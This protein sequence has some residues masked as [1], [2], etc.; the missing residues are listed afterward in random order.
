MENQQH[1]HKKKKKSK[2]KSKQRVFTKKFVDESVNKLKRLVVNFNERGDERFYA[3]K[4]DN[5]FCVSKTSNS[6]Y[7][8]DYKEF[9][10]GTT[11][12]I[13]VVMYFGNSNNCNR[14]I[15]YLKENALGST[16]DVD[17]DKK[18]SDAL[19]KKDQDYLIQSLQEQVEQQEEYIQQ[20]EEE[21]EKSS[22]KTDI[23]GILKEGVALLGAIKGLP[24]SSNTTQLSG[25]ESKSDCEVSVEAVEETDPKEDKGKYNAAFNDVYEQFGDNGMKQIVGL[26]VRVSESEKLRK[27]INTLIEKDNQENKE[28]QKKSS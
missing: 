21:L 24:I 19:K 26:M 25:T 4:V 15:F 12:S 9:I 16:P 27:D 11:E 17:V 5:E 22:S 18:I 20:L 23:Q 2:A 10:D 13:E 28:K 7:F 14:H 1:I 6:N 8:D 3:I